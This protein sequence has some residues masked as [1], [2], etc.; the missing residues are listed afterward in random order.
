MNPNLTPMPTSNRNLFRPATRLSFLA[1]FLASSALADPLDQWTRRHPFPNWAAV[2]FGS[3]QFVTVGESGA[4]RSSPDGVTWTARNAATAN[5]LADV[6]YANG[7]FVAVGA[8]GT[9]R[10]SANGADWAA[11]SSGVASSLAGIAYGGGTYVVVGSSGR[12]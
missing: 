7:K 11:A 4:V 1:L 3:N 5:S 12:Y 10:V 2:A 9:I 8:S 6:L